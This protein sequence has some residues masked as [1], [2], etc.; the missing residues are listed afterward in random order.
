MN[1]K[2]FT[3]MELL[4]VIV[5]VAVVSVA[6]T[7]SFSNIDDETASKELANTYKDIQRAASLYLDLHDAAL[8]Q[9]INESRVTI[10]ISTLQEENYVSKDI[11]NPIT[12]EQIDNS[13]SVVIYIAKD[14]STKKYVNT[15]IV[16]FS[17]SSTTCIANSEGN[18]NCTYDDS[19]PECK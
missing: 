16:N 4:V 9:F 11:T 12:G 8:E 5:I 7:V 10:K 6:S 19:I 3:L 13:S 18:S 1:K 15:C 2:G 14:G 17:Q